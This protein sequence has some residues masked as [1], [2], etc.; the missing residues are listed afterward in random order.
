MTPLESIGPSIMF[1]SLFGVRDDVVPATVPSV[2]QRS[3]RARHVHW[4][5]PEQ[6]PAY[7]I[8][9]HAAWFSNPVNEL[10]R[11]VPMGISR[12]VAELQFNRRTATPVV[13]VASAENTMDSFSTANLSKLE[14]ENV[15]IRWLPSDLIPSQHQS[16]VTYRCLEGWRSRTTYL[17]TPSSTVCLSAATVTA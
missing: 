7:D 6:V 8:S 2:Q 3:T 17:P 5:Q 4:D 1:S 12:T 15:A 14:E 10:V 13:D 16:A 11:G 9:S